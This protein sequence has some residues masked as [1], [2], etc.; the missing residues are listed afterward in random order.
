M[1]SGLLQKTHFLGLVCNLS[2]FP[3]RYSNMSH[4]STP[5]KSQCILELSCQSKGT[6]GTH[7]RLCLQLVLFTTKEAYSKLK[8]KHKF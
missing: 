6:L 5:D 3:A 2:N 1:P 4:T 7:L 8:P